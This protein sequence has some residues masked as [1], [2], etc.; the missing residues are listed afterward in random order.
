MLLKNWIKQLYFLPPEKSLKKIKRKIFGNK[1]KGIFPIDEV[2]GSKYMRG[3][4]M[5]DFLVRYKIIVQRHYPLWNLD[6][7]N[8]KVL[9][10]GGGPVLGWAPLA[11][12]MGCKRYVHIEPMYNSEITKHPNT[13]RLFMDIYKDLTALY[14]PKMSSE[15]FFDALNK[16]VVVYKKYLGDF[17]EE[18]GFEVV[19]SN[20]TLEHIVDLDQALHKLSN[21]VVQGNT[22]LHLVDFGNHRDAVNPFE[23]IYARTPDEYFTKYGRNLNLLRCSDIIRLLNK[24][25]FPAEL[26]P[27]YFEDY[28]GPI[29]DW[30]SHRYKKD[31]L[32][33]KVGFFV[34]KV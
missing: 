24:N 2:M 28:S 32:F 4:R 19:L 22:F 8:K 33:L 16:N 15:V 6:F 1:E 29:N 17:T 25:G 9:E 14:G 10:I 18:N 27:Y 11:I 31:D 7:F 23:G 20:S 21:V 26:V 12:F 34:N 3:H 30:W 13:K 5:T